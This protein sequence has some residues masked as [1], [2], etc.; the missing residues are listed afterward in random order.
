MINMEQCEEDW[1]KF[2]AEQVCDVDQTV[3]YEC[4]FFDDSET[5]AD[6]LGQLVVLGIN[7]ATSSLSWEY[8]VDGETLPEAGEY[9]IITNWKG[10]PICLS[11][12]L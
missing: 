10:D 2:I 5:M 6:E 7:T 8:E 1:E 9:S 12:C 3:L 4:W 11:S